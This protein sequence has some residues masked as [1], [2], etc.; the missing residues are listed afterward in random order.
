MFYIV[1]TCAVWINVTS[2]ANW[3]GH[4]SVTE[5]NYDHSGQAVDLINAE[6]GRKTF[7]A[8]CSSEHLQL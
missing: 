4:L 7:V 6:A 8:Q 1:H 3:H 5:P 2:Y